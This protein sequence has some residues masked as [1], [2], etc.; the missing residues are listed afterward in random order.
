MWRLSRSTPTIKHR[1]I[2]SASDFPGGEELSRDEDDA[3]D[4]RR[5]LDDRDDELLLDFVLCFDGLKKN[6][7]GKRENDTCWH[8]S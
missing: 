3:D 8:A 2:S 6:K 7:G 4:A 1:H 5:L